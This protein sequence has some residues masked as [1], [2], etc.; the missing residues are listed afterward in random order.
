MAWA[1]FAA[2]GGNRSGNN[3]KTAL[4]FWLLASIAATQPLCETIRADA[5]SDLEALFKAQNPVFDATVMARL[6]PGDSGT[7]AWGSNLL[8]KSYLLMYEATDDT[9]Y[10]DQFVKFCG[11]I[12]KVRAD[13]LGIRDEIRGK[14]VPGWSSTTF[15]N[16]IPTVHPVHTGMITYPIARFVWLVKSR[17]EL[18]QYRAKADEYLPLIEES[19]TEHDD[20]WRNGPFDDEG[21]YGEIGSWPTSLNRSHTLGRT[22]LMLWL[23]TGKPE[24]LDKVERIAIYFKRR[25]T[26]L[27]DGTVDWGHFMPDPLGRP[28]WDEDLPH[29]GQS[30]DFAAL[31]AQHGVVFTRAD[32]LCFAK[33]LGEKVCLDDGTFSSAV[34]GRI[35]PTRYGS[36]DAMRWGRLFQ[37]DSSLCDK[38]SPIIRA[39]LTGPG[40]AS[41]GIHGPGVAIP[42]LLIAEKMNR[43]KVE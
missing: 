41:P 14:V 39:E 11:A 36:R 17:P 21:E 12:W 26:W 3:N 43:S 33:T 13:R 15:S 6:F 16:G 37:F 20:L 5:S 40:A 42:Y 32:I 28:P 35:W 2:T 18:E 27:A 4:L 25:I 38:L 19:I 22:L 29:S 1:R 9:A 8:F 23:A 30:V 24:Y 31:R 7:L 10:L 34:S